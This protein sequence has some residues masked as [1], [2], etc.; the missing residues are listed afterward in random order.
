MQKANQMPN[1]WILFFEGITALIHSD[2]IW[3]S[4]MNHSASWAKH[5]IQAVVISSSSYVLSEARAWQKTNLADWELVETRF[6]RGNHSDHCLLSETSSEIT[7]TIW[8]TLS[9]RSELMSQSTAVMDGSNFLHWQLGMEWN[10]CRDG[11]MKVKL[12]EDRWWQM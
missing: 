12:D 2:S 5:F 6:C 8:A 11:M 9:R 4:Y 1:I 3:P 10:F 7:S